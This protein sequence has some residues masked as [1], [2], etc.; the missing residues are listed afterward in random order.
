MSERAKVHIL[1]RA[2]REALLHGAVVLID[3]LFDDFI[4][5]SEGGTVEDTMV[6]SDLPPQFQHH[7]K[8]LFVKSFIVCVVRVADRLARW[9][10]GTIPASTAEC[11]ALR[12][13]IERAKLLLEMKGK[14]AGKDQELD[15]DLFEEVAFPDLDIEL[16]FDLALDGIEDTDVARTMGMVLK[17]SEWFKPTY[18]PVHPYVLDERGV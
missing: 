8:V 1:S 11:L 17:P 12:L 4:H 13:I 16:L 2:Q 5:I 14:V 3:E 15:F 9:R 6:L 7:Y 18:G 10:G